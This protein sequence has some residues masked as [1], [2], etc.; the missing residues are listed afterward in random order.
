MAG[1]KQQINISFYMVGS[2][3]WYIK[4][5]TYVHVYLNTTDPKI[6]SKFEG[7]NSFIF[8]KPESQCCKGTTDKHVTL[9]IC[10]EAWF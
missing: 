10:I 8:R 6:V 9:Y 4:Y 5:K 1:H 2:S 7:K 3:H